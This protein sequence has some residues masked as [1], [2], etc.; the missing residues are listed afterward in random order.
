MPKCWIIAGPNGAGKTTFAL[1]YLANVVG[2][3]HFIN[4]DLIAAGLSPLAPE[5]ELITAGKLL[6]KEVEN[7]IHKKKD[8][9]VETTLAGKNYLKLIKRLKAQNW[10]VDLIYLALPSVELSKERVTERVKHG[11]HNIPV[12]ALERRF[13]KSLKNL[14]EEYSKRVDNCVCFINHLNSPEI[15][16]EK[17]IAGMIVAN[18]YYYDLLKK[19][20]DK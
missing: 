19:K 14:F 17:N 11:G 8:F 13:G 7:C 3:T 6:L 12:T 10:D 2:C 5:Q 20:A 9:A 18:Q 16:F 4:A 1:E 15:V